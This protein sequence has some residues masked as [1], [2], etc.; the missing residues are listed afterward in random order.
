MVDVG[1]AQEHGAGE[2]ELLVQEQEGH[3]EVGAET[4]EEGAGHHLKRRSRGGIH[5]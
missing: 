1:V 3:E 2:A 5:G 4:V